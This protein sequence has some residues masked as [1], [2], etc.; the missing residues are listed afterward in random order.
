MLNNFTDV[1]STRRQF[2]LSFLQW[3]AS[4]DKDRHTMYTTFRDYYYGEHE[5]MLTDRLKEFLQ[6][7]AG[8]TFDHN[9]LAIPIDVLAER[10]KV[11]DFE[12]ED[13]AQKELLGVWWNQ[14]RMNAKQFDVHATAARDADTYV[15]VEWSSATGQPVITH[16][17]AYDGTNGVEV[18]Y[19]DGS[20]DKIAAIKKWRV[21]KGPGSAADQRMNVYYADRIEKYILKP[22]GMDI[23]WREYTDE[24]NP[25]FPIPWVDSN[26]KP[27]GVPVFHARNRSLGN[28]YGVSDL[29]DLIPVQDLLNKSVIDLAAAADAQGF[30]V[31]T[32]TGD[33]PPEGLVMS[34]GTLWHAANPAAKFGHIPPGDLK[35]L[36]ETVEKAILRISQISRTPLSYFQ[37]TGHIASADTQKSG[38]AG[39]LAKAESSSLSLGNFWEDVMGFCRTL[40]NT[41][42]RTSLNETVRI[43]TVWDSFERIDQAAEDVRIA[44]LAATKAATFIAL[45]NS[46]L[47]RKVS[48][49]RAGYTEEEAEEMAASGVRLLPRDEVVSENINN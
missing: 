39:L 45:V 36:I 32:L 22:Q 41:F 25:V 30:S 13:E 21:E 49:S 10:L 28:D 3:L 8:I 16:E 27:L 19:G 43:S 15:I 40:S 38:E 23:S 48:A 4:G 44:D 14:N 26:R 1:E 42:D 7:N 2:D 6:L 9:Y 47:D 18:Y 5:T 34:P 24:S 17:L 29:K 20:Q 33:I 35:G 12:C 37:V 46:G 11:I 31:P